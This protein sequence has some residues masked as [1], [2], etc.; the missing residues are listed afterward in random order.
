[1][2]SSKCCC[3][4]LQ[5]EILDLEGV[6]LVKEEE[7]KDG[8]YLKSHFRGDEWRTQKKAAEHDHL[9]DAPIAQLRQLLTV[10]LHHHR[11]TFDF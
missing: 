4:P 9:I 2:V 1:M 7:I 5:V 6:N 10:S 11:G 8:Y 3:P